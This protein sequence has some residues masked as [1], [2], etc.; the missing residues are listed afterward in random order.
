MRMMNWIM[1][2]VLCVCIC[3]CEHVYILVCVY[4]FQ[5]AHLCVLLVCEW[6]VF[7]GD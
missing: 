5:C 3:V 6:D 1:K 4:V 7:E 2:R